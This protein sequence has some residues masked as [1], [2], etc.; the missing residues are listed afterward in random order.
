MG[1]WYSGGEITGKSLSPLLGTESP[2]EGS[3]LPLCL[4]S[5]G[6]VV[7]QRQGSWEP[8][9]TVCAIITSASKLPGQM[10]SPRWP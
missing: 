5:S 9:A 1:L 8:V 3:Q 4:P 6:D 2:P 10:V 7:M